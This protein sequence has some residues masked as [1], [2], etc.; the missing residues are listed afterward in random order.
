MLPKTHRGKA[1]SQIPGVTR[2][3]WYIR[4]TDSAGQNLDYSEHLPLRGLHLPLRGLPWTQ[5]LFSFKLLDHHEINSFFCYIIQPWRADSP[6]ALKERINQ[7]E[8]T[9]KTVSS[10]KQFSLV[11]LRISHICFNYKKT[12]YIIVLIFPILFFY[13]SLFFGLVP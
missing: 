11:K 7:T 2:W 1:W 13:F 12:D 5:S 6:Q 8:D 10:N 3:Q 4:E 9:S